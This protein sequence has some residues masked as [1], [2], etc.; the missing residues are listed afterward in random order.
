M[1]LMGL[2]A[3]PHFEKRSWKKLVAS[4]TKA[5]STGCGRKRTKLFLA[6]QKKKSFDVE[7]SSRLPPPAVELHASRAVAHLAAGIAGFVARI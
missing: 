5:V 3:K 1:K 2:L 6:P 4:P 7:N